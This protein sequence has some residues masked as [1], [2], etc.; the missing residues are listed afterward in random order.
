MNTTHWPQ[1]LAPIKTPKAVLESFVESLNGT[2]YPVTGS[3]QTSH[4]E[5]GT[6]HL[7][8]AN[9][10]NKHRARIIAIASEGINIWPCRLAL[11]D[12][13]RIVYTDKEMEKELTAWTHTDEVISMLSVLCVRGVETA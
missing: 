12:G 8:Q 3:I 7:L 9:C 6:T 5:R 10:I 4:T 11:G 13:T 2:P 1:T